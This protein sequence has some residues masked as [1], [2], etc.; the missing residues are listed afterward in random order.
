[1]RGGGPFHRHLPS[2]QASL[3]LLPLQ[4]PHEMGGG[5]GGVVRLLCGLSMPDLLYFA[6]QISVLTVLLKN[7][8]LVLTGGVK[9]FK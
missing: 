5:K 6:F 3:L 2:P 4:C 8:E 1:M 7:L 9:D